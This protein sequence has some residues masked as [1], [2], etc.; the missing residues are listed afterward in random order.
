MGL[1]FLPR[2]IRKYFHMSGRQRKHEISMSLWNVPLMYIAA[3]VIVAAATIFIDIYF[4]VPAQS[5]FYVFDYQTT[6]SLVST[7]ISSVL[8]L[9]AFTLNILLVL[10]TTFSG[11]FSPRMLQNFIADRQTQHYVG[12][13]NGSFI[14]VLLIFLF[15]SNFQNNDFVLVP[16]I[17]VLLAFVT[18]VIFL[19]FINHAIYWMQVHNVTF[20][21]K[22]TSEKIIQNTLTTDVEK[23]KKVESGNL[24]ENFRG[25]TTQVR[26]D[27][28]GYLQLVDFAG[29][30]SKA[31]EDDIIIEFHEKVGNF[32]LNNNPLF[33]YWGEGAAEVDEEGYRDFILYGNKELEIQDNDSA[34]SK[35]A[36]VAIKAAD[37]GDPRSAIN[38]IYQLA[39]LMQTIDHHITFAPYLADANGEVRVITP[40]QRFADSLYRGFGMI[41]YYA[42][43]NLPIIIEIIASLRMLAQGADPTRHA[44]IWR[45]AENTIMNVSQDIVYDTDRNLLLE[46]VYHLAKITGNEKEYSKLEKILQQKEA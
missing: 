27:F 32:M 30:V 7:L 2:E 43:D 5:D 35:L 29:M 12:I 34:M 17:T 41:R 10:L 20:N 1:K 6:Q 24:K 14:Y 23:L 21:M 45:F 9:S 19:F 31:Q 4:D 33:S 16:I 8:L 39:N 44:D 22:R 40:P 37:N 36:E 26:T 15:I 38:A 25:K 11:Q 42:K 18:A 13:F 46:K 3:A 28:A